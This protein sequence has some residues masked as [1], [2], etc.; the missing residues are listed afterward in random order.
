MKNL[1]KLSRENLSS[2][3]GGIT[4]E[5]AQT[6]ASASYCHPKTTPPQEGAVDACNKWCY[7]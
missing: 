4:W 6:Q 3:K 5:C 2:L 1:K 7:F